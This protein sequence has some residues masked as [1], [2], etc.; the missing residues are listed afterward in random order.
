MPLSTLSLQNVAFLGATSGAILEWLMNEGAGSTLKDSSANGNTGF[1]NGGWSTSNPPPGAATYQT[2][3]PSFSQSVFSVGNPTV[4]V[5]FQGSKIIT[6]DFWVQSSDWTQGGVL[7]SKTSPI[8][9][10]IQ[11][12]GSGQILCAF[13]DGAGHSSNYNVPSPGDTNWHHFQIVLNNTNGTI[14]AYMDSGSNIATFSSSNW[15][16]PVVFGTSTFYV[17]SLANV[18]GFFLGNFSQVK[19]Y[20]G[21]THTL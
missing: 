13:Q 6:F 3:D 9:I 2:F 15:T 19:I 18:V 4:Q 17:A 1:T 16:T 21:D 11:N 14:Q 10:E 12:G 20:S 8:N 5:N 7:F